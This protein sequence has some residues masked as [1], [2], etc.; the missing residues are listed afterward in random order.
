TAVRCRH[1]NEETPDAPGGRS[2]SVAGRL[3]LSWRAPNWWVPARL[4]ERA[5]GANDGV[6]SVA[7]ATWGED[8]QAWDADHVELV[9]WPRPLAAQ[10]RSEE[11]IAGYL[12]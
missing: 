4:I 6:V 10:S 1:F 8:C 5:E 12:K 2:F 11:R 9:N 7:S 3:Q